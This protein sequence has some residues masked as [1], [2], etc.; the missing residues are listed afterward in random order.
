M[1]EQN[2]NRAVIY[3]SFG[4]PEVLEIV[5]DWPCPDLKPDSVLIKVS[6]VSL[7]PK[8]TLLRKGKFKAMARKPLP[9]ATALDASGVVVDV[10]DRVQNVSVGDQVFGMTNVFSGGL[11]SEYVS[12]PSDELARAPAAIS[13]AEAAAIPLAALTA[14]QALRDCATCGDQSCILVIGGSGG[15]GHFAVQIGVI[16]GAQVHGAS[17]EDNLGYMKSLGATKVVDYRSQDWLDSQ[18]KYDVI[19]DVSG[20]YEPKQFKHQ[21]GASG[22]F[23]STVPKASSI[24]GELLARLNISKKYRLVIVRSKSADLQLLADWVNQGR[25]KPSIARRY[26]MDEIVEAHRQ[27]E[28]GHTRGKVIVTVS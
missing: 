24:W 8:D 28:T 9:R 2:N 10:G 18:Q 25:L 5:D 13:L 1:R 22:V 21:L 27:I 6:A 23:I 19:F 4:R 3:R 26:A 14:L 15:V 11:L 7:N 16:L 17:S 20:R 12:L